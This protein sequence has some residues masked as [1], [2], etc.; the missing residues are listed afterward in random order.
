MRSFPPFR[1][2]LPASVSSCAFGVLMRQRTASGGEIRVVR[3]LAHSPQVACALRLTLYVGTGGCHPAAGPAVSSPGRAV[4]VSRRVSAE[5]SSP[6]ARLAHN[7]ECRR[8]ESCL[9]NQFRGVSAEPRR[10]RGHVWICIHGNPIRRA[11][12]AAGVA[13]LGR[14]PRRPAPGRGDRTLRSQI[15]P[16]P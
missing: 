7:Q 2:S 11:A 4:V 1:P 6:V 14:Q 5:W 9:R 15:P 12:K 3:D 16:A 10:S 8:F 13:L